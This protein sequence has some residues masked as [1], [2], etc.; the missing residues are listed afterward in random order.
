MSIANLLTSNAKEY[1]DVKIN[2]LGLEREVVGLDFGVSD[3]IDITKFSGRVS[4]SNLVS[5]PSQGFT[6]I[7]LNNPV[8]TS[9]DSVTVILTPFTSNS[10]A[11]N[12]Y[13]YAVSNIDSG[14]CTINIINQS[15]GA[16]PTFAD[17]YYLIV[18]L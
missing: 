3:N 1:L 14:S 5:V 17:F 6:P 10:V 7:L 18:F 4:V 13:R 11:G 15:T 16:G 8:F 12:V 2:T 9:F